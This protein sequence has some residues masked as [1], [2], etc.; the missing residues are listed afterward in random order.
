MRNKIFVGVLIAAAFGTLFLFMA[1]QIPV[2]T[3][4][5]NQ[6]QVFGT[7]TPVPTGGGVTIQKRFAVWFPAPAISVTNGITNLLP[8]TSIQP[9]TSSGTVTVT[10]LLTNTLN[11]PRGAMVYFYNT[12]ATSII[13]TN[14]TYL[15]LPSASNLTLGIND[16]VTLWFD[17]T[18][19]IAFASVN[20]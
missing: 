8:V 6:P 5:S 4:D 9:L 2:T 14:G 1:S 3:P 7:T 20:N 16:G 12:S 13:F 10:S 19:W 15:V 11:V 18:K 17:G